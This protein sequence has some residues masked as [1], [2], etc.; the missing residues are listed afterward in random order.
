MPAIEEEAFQFPEI[1]NA[2][3]YSKSNPN[4]SRR[5]MLEAFKDDIIDRPVNYTNISKLKPEQIVGASG[6]GAQAKQMAATL[7]K[8]PEN[9]YQKLVRGITE[10]DDCRAYLTAHF[11]TIAI[12]PDEHR[13]ALHAYCS[14]IMDDDE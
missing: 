11:D 6:T 7:N 8:N 5:N 4:H 10:A 3:L 1:S 9:T 14:S 12:L 2:D 13:V